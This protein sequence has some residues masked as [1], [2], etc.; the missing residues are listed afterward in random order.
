MVVFFSEILFDCFKRNRTSNF[1]YMTRDTRTCSHLW[2][3]FWMEVHFWMKFH[4]FSTFSYLIRWTCILFGWIMFWFL[5]NKYIGSMTLELGKLCFFFDEC[6]VWIGFSLVRWMR[7]C[8]DESTDGQESHCSHW[9]YIYSHL[10]SL[11]FHFFCE[12][13]TQC[14]QFVRFLDVSLF[15]NI[16]DCIALRIYKCTIFLSIFVLLNL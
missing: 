5:L 9:P 16:F 7:I 14:S 15:S 1:P 10:L 3:E 8:L 6:L 4:L 13:Q 12:L 2:W 11:S